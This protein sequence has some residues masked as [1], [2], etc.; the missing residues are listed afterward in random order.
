MEAQKRRKDGYG[1]IKGTAPSGTCP[2]CFQPMPVDDNLV[3]DLN[4]NSIMSNGYIITVPPRTAELVFYLRQNYPRTVTRD[5]IIGRVWCD[6]PD[7]ETRTIDGQATRARIALHKIGWDIRTEYGIGIRLARLN[8][9]SR[10]P[11]RRPTPRS[12]P[13]QPPSAAHP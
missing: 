6:R 7:T 13:P 5:Q 10:P 9:A 2:C 11:I 12:E 3:V 4:T 1:R 8:L